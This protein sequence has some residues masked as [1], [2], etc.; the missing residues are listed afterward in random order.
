[1]TQLLQYRFGSSVSGGDE[2]GTPGDLRGHAFG[3]LLLAALAGITGS[4]DEALLAAQRVLAVRGRVVPSTLEHITLVAEVLVARGGETAVLE[5][6]VGESAIPKAGGKIQRVELEPA[7]VRAYPPALRAIFQ[8]DLIV[9]GPGSLYTSILPNLLISDLAEALKHARA[10]KVY[11]CN[12]ATQPGETDSYTVADHVH[13]LLDHIPAGCLNVVLAND[14]LS[15]AP[16][17]G[18]GRTVFVQPVPPREEVRL[19]TADL[20]DEKRPWRHDSQ[21]VAK[22]VMELITS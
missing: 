6:V 20:V 15:A 8:A 3:N 22:R 14:N 12:L 18:G 11:V 21:K 5:R 4:F 2:N 19:V 1:M 17:A 13:A 10:P 16:D 9:M 7:N